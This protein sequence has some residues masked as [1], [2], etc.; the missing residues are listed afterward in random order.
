[1]TELSDCETLSL[2]QMGT[3]CKRGWSRLAAVLA[4]GSIAS[5]ALA[6]T[7]TQE[8]QVPTYSESTGSEYVLLPVQVFDGKGRFV[9][10]LSQS[11]FQVHVE[12]V[13]VDVDTF[14]RDDKAPVSYAFLIDTS[15]SMRLA[16]KLEHA[17]DAVRAIIA[18]RRPGDD[19]ALFAF[20]E[21]E[22]RQVSPF[23]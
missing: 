19:F 5:A 12:G 2:T 16:D 21:D 3:H 9:Q 13:N 14:E 10:G 11:D 7:S 4:A 23:S 6:Q 17:K 18:R 20:S 15:G 8:P 1:G 22:V